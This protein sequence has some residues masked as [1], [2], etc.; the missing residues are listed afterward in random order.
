MKS[1][2]ARLRAHLLLLVSLILVPSVAVTAANINVEI[3]RE[4]ATVAQL[5]LNR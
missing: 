3:G 1:R 4:S 2:F 5:I